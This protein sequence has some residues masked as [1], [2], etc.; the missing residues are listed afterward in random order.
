LPVHADPGQLG[1]VLL[2]LVVN[3]RD[4]MSNGGDLHIST[5]AR[6]GGATLTV[7]DTGEGMDAETQRRIFEP[8]FTTKGPGKGTGMGLS[9]VDGIIEQSGGSIEVES[10][11]GRGATFRIQLQPAPEAAEAIDPYESGLHAAPLRA[12]TVLLVEDEPLVRGVIEQMLLS[13]GHR[14]LVAAGPDAALDVAAAGT[15]FDLVLTDVVMPEMNGHEL[16]SRLAELQPRARVLYI[17]GYTGEAV[18]ARGVLDA[19]D[20]FLQKPF[21]V[22]ALGAKVRNALTARG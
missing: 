9:T 22:D 1:Q 20:A 18:E 12:A 14:V 16:A 15:H 21:T 7:T 11:P 2:N 10:A 6:G 3:A 8:F 17:S 4:A 13:L 19:K 5:A